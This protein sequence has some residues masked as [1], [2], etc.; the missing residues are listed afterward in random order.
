VVST[1]PSEKYEFVSWDDE[2]P[3]IRKIIKNLWFQSAPTRIEYPKKP[4]HWI[5]LVGKITGNPWVLTI[6]PSEI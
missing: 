1:N 5:G 6:R 2:I 4:Y 3:Q